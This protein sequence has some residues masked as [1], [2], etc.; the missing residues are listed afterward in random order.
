[1]DSAFESIYLRHQLGRSENQFTRNHTVQYFSYPQYKFLRL[2]KEAS[3]TYETYADVGLNEWITLRLEVMGEK[4]KLYINDQKHPS[5]IVEKM[6][7][8]TTAG[9]MALW[10]D[11]GTEGYFKDLKI[12]KQ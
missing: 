5:F 1:M 7:G 3:G 6:K 12:R 9:L 4:A 2:R 11:I 8:Q 10:V